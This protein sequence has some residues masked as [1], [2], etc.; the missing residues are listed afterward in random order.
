MLSPE[1]IDAT[2]RAAALAEKSGNLT[3]LLNWVTSRSLIALDAGDLP[4]AIA[5]ADQA[6]ELALREG[7]PT[8]LG[9]AHALQIINALLAWRPR[10]R[11]EAFHGRA[12]VFRRPRLQAIPRSSRGGSLCMASWNAWLQGR[13]RCC[14]RAKAQMMATVNANNPYDLACQNTMA[15]CSGFHERIRASRGFGGPGA[16]A[17]GETSNSVC[18][19][20]SRCVLGQA[21]AQLGRATEGIAL[22]RQGIAGMLEAGARGSISHY[23]ASLAPRRNVKAPSSTRW[24]R[25]SRRSRRI[26]TRS[27]TGPK[28]SGY[29]ANCGS[30]RGRQNWPRPTS[31]RPSRSRRRWSAKAWELRATMSLARLLDETGPP[32]RGAHDARRNLRL[33]HRG[34]RHRRPE[35]RKGTARRTDG[36]DSDAVREV[37]LRQPRRR[38][39]LHEVRRPK[40]RIVALP[41]TP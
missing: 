40:S 39:V 38:N 32:R 15:R 8:S 10:G 20:V 29:A 5:L 13:S 28:R 2:E 17:I 1:T 21:R 33:V 22:I 35:G 36:I 4:A 26:P 9:L 34:L 6:L 19:S 11:R 23:I 7:S 25:S 27:S 37:Q 31:A 18:G 30:N 12:Q 24:K 14:P 16:R 41:V 3:Q